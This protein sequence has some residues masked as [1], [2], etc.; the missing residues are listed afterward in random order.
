MKTVKIQYYPGKKKSNKY[1]SFP[2]HQS[3]ALP[4]TG[5][6]NIYEPLLSNRLKM[7]ELSIFQRT[8]LPFP[9]HQKSLLLLLLL[10]HPGVVPGAWHRSLLVAGGLFHPADDKQEIAFRNAV[11]KINADR[12]ILPRS[13]LSAQIEKI[14]PQ[15]SFHASKRGTHA[16]GGFCVDLVVEVCYFVVCHLLRSGVAAIFGPQSAHTASH[17]QSICDTMEIPHLETRWDYRLRRESCLVNLYP[18]PTTLSKV[19][20]VKIHKHISRV[21]YLGSEQT[22]RSILCFFNSRKKSKTFFS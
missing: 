9:Q 12:S 17:V 8:S 14:S 19:T 20:N 15:D 7:R 21:L 6:S 11:E 16:P 10:L 22:L 13:K 2:S 18:H 4:S 1:P 3:T 5:H